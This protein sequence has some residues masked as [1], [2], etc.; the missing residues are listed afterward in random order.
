MSSISYVRKKK[1]HLHTH[2]ARCRRLCCSRL[3]ITPSRD[4]RLYLKWLELIDRTQY[5]FG[6]SKKFPSRKVTYNVS[7]CNNF[8]TSESNDRKLCIRSTDNN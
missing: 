5:I 7:L 3:L 8:D 4:V 2:T 6:I 1:N